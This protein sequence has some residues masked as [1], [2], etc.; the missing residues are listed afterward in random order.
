ELLDNET[1]DLIGSVLLA[2]IDRNIQEVEQ[3]MT[4]LMERDTEKSAN[5]RV[6][7][8]V[9]GGWL[10]LRNPGFQM[11]QIFVAQDQAFAFGIEGIDDPALGRLQREFFRQPQRRKELLELFKD[12]AL[13]QT[14]I[15][16]PVFTLLR[17]FVADFELAVLQQL[18]RGC[19]RLH[20]QCH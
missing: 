13:F 7:A 3:R 12:L 18:R 15:Y 10:F 5:Q 19:T 17:F 16:G 4:D 6:L 20:K 8:G 9:A 1:S 14:F 11:I 2:A